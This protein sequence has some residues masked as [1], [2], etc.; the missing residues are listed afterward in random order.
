MKILYMP[1]PRGSAALVS[2]EIITR[3]SKRNRVIVVNSRA[4]GKNNASLSLGNE[5]S[6]QLS[7]TF[8]VRRV[9]EGIKI[10]RRFN[11]DVVISQY[12]PQDMLSY[13]AKLISESAKKPLIVRSDDIWFVP[14]GKLSF[15]SKLIHRLNHGVIRNSRLFLVNS[16]EHKHMI[17]KIYGRREGVLIHPNGVD[18]TRFNPSLAG[19]ST[20]RKLGLV[21]RRVVLYSGAAAWFYGLELLPRAFAVVAREVK[22]ATLLLV[23]LS[24]DRRQK[25]VLLKEIERNGVRNRTKVLPPVPYEEIHEFIALSD[26][27]IGT[28]SS[29]PVN[30]GTIPTKVPQYM[31]CGKPTIV[32]KGGVTRD[33][34][35]HKKTGITFR[36]SHLELA[37]WIIKL[38]EDDNLAKTI[39]TKARNHVTRNYDWSKLV[40][41]LEELISHAC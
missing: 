26:V 39:G 12:H 13:A 18:T 8:P 41:Q 10:A 23:G 24:G 22:D 15:L 3:L 37:K 31:A 7:I 5:L 17:E 33:L 20:K 38:L 1:F 16:T 27:C 40:M 9:I 21:D 6:D 11:P 28:L 30:I 29:L 35:I 36:G 32:A 14:S 34:I 25:E 4:N 2:H 19:Y